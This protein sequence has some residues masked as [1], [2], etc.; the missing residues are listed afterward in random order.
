MYQFDSSYS[1]SKGGTQKVRTSW[2]LWTVTLAP[3]ITDVEYE[4]ASLTVYLA[5]VY[6]MLLTVQQHGE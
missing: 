3:P 6:F 2:H 5:N 1:R 4:F